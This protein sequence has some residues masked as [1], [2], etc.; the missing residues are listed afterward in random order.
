MSES[1]SRTRLILVRLLND[2]CHLQK[3]YLSPV[4]QI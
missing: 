2:M 1:T 4:A 3:D